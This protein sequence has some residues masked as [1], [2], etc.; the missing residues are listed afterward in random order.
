MAIVLLQK[1]EAGDTKVDLSHADLMVNEEGIRRSS[2]ARSH[3]FFIRTHTNTISKSC[4][5]VFLDHFLG[6]SQNW[7]TD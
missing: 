2:S 6:Q 5:F 4:W 7:D 3:T 1:Q